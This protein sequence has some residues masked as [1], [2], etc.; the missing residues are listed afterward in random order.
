MSSPIIAT[1][2]SLITCLSVGLFYSDIKLNLTYS[3]FVLNEK[4]ILLFLIVWNLV[5]LRWPP[6]TC[7]CGIF[8]T[9]ISLFILIHF[10][11]IFGIEKN[12]FF[13][14]QNPF[15]Q[16]PKRPSILNKLEL[17]PSPILSESDQQKRNRALRAIEEKLQSIDTI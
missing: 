3:I 16:N 11:H 9:I 8:S 15:R 13:H 2:F 1:P 12:Q 7:I 4:T 14:F 17:H 5:C 10:S 6:F